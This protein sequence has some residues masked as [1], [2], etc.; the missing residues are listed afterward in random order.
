MSKTTRDG[1]LDLAD[2]R[3]L[4][5]AEWGEPDAPPVIYCHGFPGD[6]RE[7]DLITSTLAGRGVHA[8]LVALNRPGYG[9]STFQTNRRFVDW[10]ADVTEAADRLGIGRFAVLGVSGG[11]P[12]ALACGHDLDERVTRVGVVVG[13]G[14][15]AATGMEHATA[16]TGPSSNGIV[17]RAQFG[18]AAYAFR[19]GQATRFIDQSVA[20]MGDADR[21]A[22]TRPEVHDWFAEVMQE[23]FS[24]GGRGVA[25]E[26]GLYRQSW[27][28]D[29]TR[30]NVETHLWYGGRDQTVPASVGRWLDARLPESTYVVWP[31]HG[32]FS[33]MV[34]DEAAE[35]IATITQSNEPER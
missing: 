25:Y 35:V 14:P 9:A 30:I 3:S 18:M 21:E 13:L 32:H 8:R 12:Y 24:E 22:I 4:R 29:L 16:I 28:F 10:P 6:R 5:Y 11:A 34:D 20:S 27:G 17:R 1:L 19:K 33:W 15:L 2:G 23:A 26:A 31:N 7:I